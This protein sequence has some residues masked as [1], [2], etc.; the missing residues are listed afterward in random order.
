MKNFLGKPTDEPKAPEKV[1]SYDPYKKADMIEAQKHRQAHF[2]R[3]IGKALKDPSADRCMCCGFPVHADPY[4]LTCN[5]IELSE[6]GSGFPL[7]F[8]FAKIIVTIF[9]L[10]VCIVAVPCI[11]GNGLADRGDDWDADKDSW[12]IKASL[13]NQGDVPDIYPLWQCYLNIAFMVMVIILYHICRRWFE[14]KDRDFD[15]M[16]ITAKDYTVHAYGLGIDV[17]EQDIKE[18]FEK[19]GRFDGR[20]AKVIKVVF[21]YKI[22]E[23]IDN[24]RKLEELAEGLKKIEVFE[25]EGIV[26]KA[27]CCA[28]KKIVN[29]DDIKKEIEVINAE[30]KKYENELPAGV[31]RDLC[32]GQAF[33][34]F[35]TQADAR[36]VEIKFGRQWAFRLWESTFK[37]LCCCF[38]KNKVEKLRNKTIFATIANEP[39][40]IYW[41][42]LEVS[43]YH[44]FIN[45]LK[46]SAFTFLAV[47]ITFGMVYGMKIL[48]ENEQKNYNKSSEK[49][50]WKIRILSI[51]P[52]II[53]IMI[54]FILSRSTRYTTSFERP[55][56][57]TA[58]NISVG[59]KLMFAMFFNTAVIALIVNF[60]WRDDWFVPGGLATDATYII[61]SNAFISPLIYY[62]SP[63]VCIHKLKMKKVEK[64]TYISQHDA[65]L[66]VENPAVDMAQRY[67]NINK[68]VLLT[69]C[70]APLVPLAFIF[71]AIA[72]FNEYWVF[73]YLLLRRHTWPKKLSGDLA[74]TMFNII[75]LSILLYAIMNYVY[76][77]YLN[78]ANSQPAFVW[79]LVMIGYNVLPL[80]ILT[81]FCIKKD[82]TIWETTSPEKYEDV[83]LT[84]VEDYDKLNPITSSEG[85]KRFAE[86]ML[87]KNVVDKSTFEEITTNLKL[88]NVDVFKNMRKYAKG[89]KNIH[90]IEKN[91]LALGSM[92]EKSMKN[93]K[94][95]PKKNIALEMHKYL[96]SSITPVIKNLNKKSKDS[97]AP[98]YPELDNSALGLKRTKQDEPTGMIYTKPGSVGMDNRV[99]SE[100]YY[101]QPSPPA[102]FNNFVQPAP[103]PPQYAPYQNYQGY[104]APHPAYNH[105]AYGYGNYYYNSNNYWS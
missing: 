12:V 16:A 77:N 27:G 26:D 87:K 47:S 81:T 86:L 34:T 88:D 50:T 84:F 42:N 40:D 78:S 83:A 51:W 93:I 5:M 104:R 69:F 72:V 79:M 57:V 105:P 6:L 41:E 102:Q 44:R 23:Y 25:S 33:I 11:I 1:E 97:V 19:Y 95:K 85:H 74:K 13:G 15:I 36:A 45:L 71:G 82:V 32:T 64:S 20:P 49:D 100:N 22:K 75:P 52:S 7:F 90:E 91:K 54:N 24:L 46:T 68:T 17:K 35:E 94:K 14:A 8:V 63:M 59:V 66:M 101:E 21:S 9:L 98:I 96:G 3:Q 70:Y 43:F 38:S 55:H 28:G 37:S 58:Y 103:P 2:I 73:K 30:L 76:M 65:N 89:R 48:G 39:N 99:Q 56:S 62:F 92:D 61:I 53:I 67:A 10:G 31:G 29:K 18:F 80:E 4:P 60:D